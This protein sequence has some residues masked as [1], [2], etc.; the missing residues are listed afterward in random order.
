[1]SRKFL[2]RRLGFAV[3][4]ILA[5]FALVAPHGAAQMPQLK[6]PQDD[7]P[8]KPAEKPKKKVKGPRAIG[9]VQLNGGKGT[10]IPVAILVDGRFYDASVYKA[11]PVPM[12]LESGTVY[13]VEQSGSS[14]GLFTISGALHSKTAGSPHP[15]TGSGAYLPNGTEVKKTTRKAED[16]PVGLDTSS[17]DEPPRLTRGNGS[18]PAASGSSPAPASTSPAGAGS[19]EKPA[20]PPPAA[21]QPVSGSPASSPSGQ[22]S[23]KPTAPAAADKPP[24]QATKDQAAKDQATKDQ[25]PKAAQATPGQSAPSQASP[26]QT[27]PTQTS[28]GQTSPTQTASS[29][30]SPA[31]TSQ[32]QESENYYRPTLR[33]GKPTQAAPEEDEPASKTGKTDSPATATA[34]NV[35]PSQLV[36][37]ISDGGGP[38]PRPYKFFWKTGEEEERRNQ[39]LALAADEVRAYA[40]ALV[41][42][43]ISAKPPAAKAASAIHKAPAKPAQPVFGNTQFHAFDVWGNNQ[44]VM[45]LSTEAQLPS[46]PAPGATTAPETYSITLVARSDIYGN[47]RKVYSGVTDKFHLDVTPRL[48]LIDAVDADGD[49]RG[50]LLFR[51]TTDAGSGY[52]IY[53]AT[54]DKL[55]KMF[56]SLAE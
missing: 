26:S 7:T 9:V 17:N 43:R 23:Q 22:D 48:E 10:L 13:E 11:D 53:R 52:V 55:W 49:G 39:M 30:A 27:S 47:L 1:M 6:R 32:G 35:G 42:N 2:Y 14:Q 33:R 36:P 51:E 12:A 3:I 46:A 16:V 50:E 25:A 56:D 15:W 41:R 40:S 38:D 4:V 34:A 24:D 31:K 37:A 18:K 20:A 21:A 45:I 19:S 54:G 28:P 44:A 8:E 29:Q 5:L